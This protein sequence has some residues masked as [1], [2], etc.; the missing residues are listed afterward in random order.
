[1]ER[2]MGF[3]EEFYD[4]QQCHSSI[5]IPGTSLIGNGF[6][7]FC[8]LVALIWLFLGIGIISDIFMESIETITA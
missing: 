3:V 6:M 1:M 5:M 7:G 4:G 8:Y 2:K